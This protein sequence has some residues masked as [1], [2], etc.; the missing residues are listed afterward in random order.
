MEITIENPII[1]NVDEVFYAFIIEHNNQNDHYLI[2]C[3]FKLVF[4]DIQ[5][6][7]WIKSNLFDNK[8]MICWKKM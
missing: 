6:S 3:H 1:D 4:I 5:N 8:T 7:E 2:K